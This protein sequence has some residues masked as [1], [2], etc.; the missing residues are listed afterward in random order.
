MHQNVK[1]ERILTLHLGIDI[2][3]TTVKIAVLDNNDELVFSRYKRHYSDIW[4]ALEELIG[5]VYN[6]YSTDLIT[7]AVTGS[8]GLAVAEILGLNFV[9]EVVAGSKA[10]ER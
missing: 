5:E 7:A 4:K 8:G 9:Q 2:G 10:I 3:S 1:G 6:E